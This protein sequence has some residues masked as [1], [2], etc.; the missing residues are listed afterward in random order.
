MKSN[1]DLLKELEQEESD[2][3]SKYLELRK[4]QASFTKEEWSEFEGVLS[5]LN[6]VKYIQRL[7]KGTSN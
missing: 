6:H 3:E 7:I 4:T 2:L 1:E 5:K